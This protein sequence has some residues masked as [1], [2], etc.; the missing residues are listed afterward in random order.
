MTKLYQ[1]MDLSFILNVI[2][3]YNVRSE[4]GQWVTFYN[5]GYIKNRIVF[6][7]KDSL[8]VILTKEFRGNEV[9]P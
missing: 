9:L 7:Q 3:N 6:L 2:F 1:W 5:P 4:S 8:C